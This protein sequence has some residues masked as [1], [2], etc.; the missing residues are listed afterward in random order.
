[1][2]RR[3]LAPWFV[4]FSIAV[5]LV[6]LAC[7][8]GSLARTKPTIVL[9]SPPSGAQFHDGENVAVQSTSTDSVG[10]ARVELL[11]DDA[12]VQTDQGAGGNQISYT[13]IQTWKAKT[14]NHKISVRAYN[15]S[16]VASDPASVTVSVLPAPPAPTPTTIPTTPAEIP[17]ATAAPGGGCTYNSV[18]VTDVSIPDGTELA[19]GQTFDKIW[20][21]RNNGTCTWGSGYQLVFVSGA[22][23][24]SN[25]AVPIPTTA[26]GA[27]VDLLVSLAAPETPGTHTGVWRLKNRAGAFFGT[28]LT[29]VI[30]V[31]AP[32]PPPAATAKPVPPTRPPSTCTGNPIISSFTASPPSI[33]VGGSST[34]T[35]GMVA[36]ADSAE[37]DEGIGGIP[38]PGSLVVSPQTTTTYTLLA[39]CGNAIATRQVTV[40]VNNPD[41]GITGL[42]AGVRP[43]S[44]ST[45]PTN[46]IFSAAITAN[47]PGTITYRWERSDGSATSV[48]GL[49]FAN[50]G[51]L[52][53]ANQWSLAATTS[54]WARVHILSP[55]DATSN[56]A[57][58][59]LN[60]A[61]GF[62]VTNV[63]ASA[64][65]T[66]FA[67]ACPALLTF[68]GHV[69]ANG[70]GTATF[71]WER[72]DGAT[73]AIQSANF[74][75]G[76]EEV[77]T[78]WAI[79]VS[80]P[81]WAK[82]HVLSPNDLLSGQANYLVQCQ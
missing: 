41:F 80:G 63:L 74:T 1:M 26:P 22:P 45:C 9:G 13:V 61:A 78:Q 30:R 18:F 37:I 25:T 48:F 29:V 16:N 28:T 68:V 75:G 38:T 60:C 36:N 40:F 34:L 51:T 76:T 64:N 43:A 50:A 3:S 79:P 53:V 65:P 19:P 11:V 82:L 57:N 70:A 32:P 33:M 69:T 73:T 66:N 49:T 71:R 24:T 59:S 44:S 27:T 72:S 17:T 58:F 46:F 77:R 5:T 6:L 67:G 12:V 62:Q 21:V 20:R 35:W 2:N 23:M 15:A 8:L 54:G 52:S 56:Q 14:G 47:S 81:G 42:T 39:R 31:G 7:S 55:I 4:L 10:I